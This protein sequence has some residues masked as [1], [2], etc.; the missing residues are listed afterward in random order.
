MTDHR[1]TGP[2][3]LEQFEADISL[4]IDHPRNR[5]LLTDFFTACSGLDVRVADT[6]EPP[7]EPA[8]LVVVDSQAIGAVAPRLVEVKQ[9]AEPVFQPVLGVDSSAGTTRGEGP[10]LRSVADAV[11]TAPIQK[12][13]LRWHVR[14]LLRQRSLSIRLS[15]RNDEIERRR[16]DLRLL[17]QILEHD[18]GNHISTV[19]MAVEMLTET[20]DRTPD[21]HLDRIRRAAEDAVD[22]IET[23][24]EYGEWMTKSRDRNLSSMSLR[25]V[26]A[27]QVE[28]ARLSYPTAQ[29]EAP[30]PIPDC[31]VVADDLL[32]C[33]FRNL[34]SNAVVHNDT[35][36]PT[37]RVAVTDS[38]PA[39]EVTIADNGPG[40]PPD[41]R[42]QIFGENELDLESPGMGLGLYFV[43]ALVTDYGGSVRVEENDPRGAR[44]V[45]HLPKTSAAESTTGPADEG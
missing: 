17:N 28:T 35:D 37:V 40:V 11:V 8:D 5:E 29:F 7:D 38:K 39:V 2:P 1:S 33:V 12:T 4:I 26:L 10:S 18:I 27:D 15:H 32:A 23:A 13:R 22:L 24:R 34:L 41:M 30:E 14:S 16:Q 25:D 3:P 21:P 6:V 19:L 44:F 43:D 9:E 20:D 36:E 31:T 42:S 45:V